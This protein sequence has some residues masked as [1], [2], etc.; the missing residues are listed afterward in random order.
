MKLYVFGVT[1]MTFMEIRTIKDKTKDFERMAQF[2]A[3]A[4]C[5]GFQIKV[6]FDSSLAHWFSIG[7]FFDQN[8]H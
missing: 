2:M 4:I 7:T 1:Q 5:P 3:P 8:L 6:L